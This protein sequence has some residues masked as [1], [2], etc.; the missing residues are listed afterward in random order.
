MKIN[1]EEAKE[2]FIKYT[3]NFNTKDKNVK[4]KQQHSIRVMKIAEQIATNLKLSEEQIQL[5]TLIGLLHDIGRFKQY[6][7]I[8]LGNNLE[9]FDHGDYGTKL[10]FKG[11]LI[12]KFIETNK[13]DEI[14]K[15]SIK[16]HNKFSIEAGLTQ[17]ELLFAKLIR[18]ADKI[19][20][21]YESIDIYYKNNEE[22]VNK[23]VLSEKIYNEFTK[24]ATI[25][26]EKNVRLKFIDDITCVIAFIYDINYKTSFEIIKEKDYI[27][28]IIDR[29]NFKD[30]STK[31]KVDEIKKI[32]NEYIKEKI[33]EEK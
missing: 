8:G 26:K 25:K 16:N 7:D 2:E 23:S 6:T 10:L 12:R 3:E 33:M 20:I 1:I 9:G 29:Y 31:I 4:R 15:K 11:G 24:K 14:I 22:E 28:K 5:A 32:A 18:D 17:E 13:Y 19:D 27:N 30:Q 21:L